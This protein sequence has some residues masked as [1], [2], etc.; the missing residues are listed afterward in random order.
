M[1]LQDMAKNAVMKQIADAAVAQIKQIKPE[2]LMGQ[3]IKE[4]HGLNDQLAKDLDGDGKSEQQNI[5][6]ELE[7]ASKLF[8][9]ALNR[10]DKAQKARA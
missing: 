6:E 3:L 4:A 2:E 8:A 1:S 7:Q 10:L 5:R 9:S